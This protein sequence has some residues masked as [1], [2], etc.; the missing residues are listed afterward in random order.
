MPGKAVITGSESGIGRA[1]AVR[2]ADDGFDVGVTWFTDEKSEATAREVREHGQTAV[3]RYLDVTDHR[4]APAVVRELADELG[5]LD[6][7]VNNAGGGHR[8]PFLELSLETWRAVLDLSL[9]GAFVC[10]QA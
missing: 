5:G 1:A 8:D 3:L 2:L 10:A 9:T 7:F 6:V 4:A